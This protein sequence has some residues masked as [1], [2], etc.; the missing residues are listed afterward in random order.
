MPSLASV[1]RFI[2]HNPASVAGI[3]AG[4]GAAA[5]VGREALSGDPNK[6][7]LGAAARGA[8]VGGL[9]GGATGGIGRAARDTMLL[10]PELTGAK[11]IAKATA[12]RM[13]QGIS[14]FAQR[15]FHG[16]TGFGGKNQAYL[17]RIG[18]TGS[19]TALSKNRLVN[20]RAEDAAKFAP[21]KTEKI[22][23]DAAEKARGIAEEGVAGDRMRAL[24]MTSAPGS[25]KAMATNPRE[26][27][28]AI[29]HQLRSGGKLGIAAGVGL[30]AVMTG[31]SL[32][33]GDESAQGGQTIGEKVLRGG[34]NIGGGLLFGGLPMV[35]NMVA[36]G[37]AES[38]AGHLGRRL[39]PPRTPPAPMIAEASPRIG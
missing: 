9:L 36:G 24:G 14:N 12:Q 25:I 31:V 8:A 28:R 30:P 13:G 22:F 1:G 11:D 26:A 34:T 5:N 33:R 35:S 37:L 21:A 7:Y 32:A 29:W 16:L 27:S 19:N 17:D 18:M 2:A 4:L 15:Q 20:L 23:T 10:R 39:T 6:N 3:G 38:A